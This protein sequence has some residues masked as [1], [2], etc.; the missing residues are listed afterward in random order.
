MLDTPQK[1][2]ELMQEAL[3]F[4]KEKDALLIAH[5][6]THP[7]LQ[8]LAEMSG[9]IVSDSLDMAKFGAQSKQKNLIIAGVYFMGETAKIL[10]PDKNVYVLDP[11]ATCSLDLGCPLDE[12][13]AFCDRYPDHTVVVYANTSA[14]I[15]ARADWVV[16]SSIA[17]PVIKH[18]HKQGQSIVWGPD[19]HL[20]H[21]L[22]KETGASMVLWPGQCIVHEE[23]QGDS[24]KQL[25]QQY[26][27]AHILAHPESPNAV[28]N[29]AHTIGST[30]QLL[31]ATQGPDQHYIVATDSGI[32]YQMKKQSPHKTF[33]LAPTH[34]HG[35]TCQ[36][37]GACPWMAMNTLEKLTHCMKDTHAIPLQACFEQAR[38][39]LQKM[40]EFRV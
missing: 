38:L 36:S 24:L 25:K 34:G 4:L 6:Y 39:S 10:S 27:D 2:C 3:A 9:G 1:S 26:P 28:L 22:Q 37:C 8:E 21:Y 40:V 7:H 12:F 13:N 14:A 29:Q 19:R 16:T 17:L 5:Y 23:F 33:T 35:A 18:L 31:Q 20:G 32:F 11:K 30:K 15:K